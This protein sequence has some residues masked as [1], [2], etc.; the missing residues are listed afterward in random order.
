MPVVGFTRHEC[1][2]NA[3]QGWQLGEHGAWRKFSN[4]EIATRVPLIIAA[5]WLR[6]ASSPRRSAALVEL[7]DLLPT[8]A[9]LAG[10][11]PIT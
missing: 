6:Q 1:A 10:E 2:D 3:M 9:D 8:V 7:V 4:F 11:S 5:P